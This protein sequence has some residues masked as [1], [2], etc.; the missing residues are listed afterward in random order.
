[1]SLRLNMGFIV[2]KQRRVNTCAQLTVSFLYN[3]QFLPTYSQLKQMHLPTTVILLKMSTME[4]HHGKFCL[5]SSS[6]QGNIFLT[7]YYALY[8]IYD[9]IL[10]RAVKYNIWVCLFGSLS[11]HI[12]LHGVLGKLE[13]K[14]RLAS[15]KMTG[16]ILWNNTKVGLKEMKVI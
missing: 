7:R 10:N 2:R 16:H 1:M 12:I 4:I 15:R 3:P 9:T 8:I 6:M 5:H 14:Q 13:L 11:R